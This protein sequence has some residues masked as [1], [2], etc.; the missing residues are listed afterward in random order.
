[1]TLRTSPDPLPLH[2]EALLLA[3]RDDRGTADPY[4]NLA[5]GLGAAILAE[6]L[7][8]GRVSVETERKKKF[9]KLVDDAPTGNAL[10]DDAL[11]LLATAKR[12]AQLTAWVQKFSAIKGLMHRTAE[13]L[14]DRGVLKLEEGRVL[15]IFKRRIYPELDGRVEKEILDRLHKAIFTQTSE[16]DARTVVLVSLGNSTGLLSANFDKKKL[17]GRKRRIE[18]LVNGEVVG[19]AA[20][21]AVEEATM[22]V[23]MA[24]VIPAAV[25]T[26]VITS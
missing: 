7:L 16:V 5:L 6:L 20:T 25:S 19:K 11:D 26:T 23:M 18:Q 3:L 17:K 12:R 9:L 24:A 13:S 1:M 21:A 14:C 15:W 4:V 10:L 2:E 22:A 8:D